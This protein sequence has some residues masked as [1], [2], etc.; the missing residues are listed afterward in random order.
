MIGALTADGIEAM[1]THIGG[2]SG[3]GFE[4]F[5]RDHVVPVLEP[6][7]VVVFDHLGAHHREST[8]HRGDADR[9]A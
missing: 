5:V 7:D 2:T 6:G 4:S 1:M 3:E 8:E 9:V